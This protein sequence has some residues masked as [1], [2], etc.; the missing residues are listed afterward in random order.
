MFFATITN[1]VITISLGGMLMWG[2]IALA[3]EA[4]ARRSG[5]PRRVQDPQD[6]LWTI[7]GRF[8]LRLGLFGGA[9]PSVQRHKRY[10]AARRLRIRLPLSHAID[11][12][13]LIEDFPIRGMRKI[14]AE[15][16]K[17]VSVELVDFPLVTPRSIS[18]R[19]EA[20]NDYQRD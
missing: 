20:E 9:S 12:G 11:P 10:L 16:E 17:R 5:G 4:I 15:A 13:R 1:A 14:D 8:L 19:G 2:W 3:S 7:F 18:S 6:V